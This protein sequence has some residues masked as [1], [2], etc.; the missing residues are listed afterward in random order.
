MEK[1]RGLAPT[2]SRTLVFQLVECHV[3]DGA[4]PVPIIILIMLI[5]LQGR[6][7]LVQRII[8]LL[9]KKFLS[10]PLL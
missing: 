8:A 7:L 1:R 3:I 10:S 9:D 5:E 2:G 6:G 4:I